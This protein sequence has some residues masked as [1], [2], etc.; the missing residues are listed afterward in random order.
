MYA[1]V[2]DEHRK[3]KKLAKLCIQQYDDINLLDNDEGEQKGDGSQLLASVTLEGDSTGYSRLQHAGPRMSQTRSRHVLTASGGT[4]QLRKH[5]RKP[6]TDATKD[7]SYS[8]VRPTNLE[9]A[10][11]TIITGGYSV[12]EQSKDTDVPPPLPQRVSMCVD[13]THTVAGE[14]EAP[15]VKSSATNAG[16][17]ANYSVVVKGEQTATNADLFAEQFLA[18]VCSKKDQKGGFGEQLY[19]SVK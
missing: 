11:P 18:E 13:T 19:D 12:I 9:L 4:D 14:S 6:S 8:E 2:S 10:I 7:L 5:D 17:G 15:E 1:V 16:G 3:K